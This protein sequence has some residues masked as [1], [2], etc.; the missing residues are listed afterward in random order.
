MAVLNTHKGLFA[1]NRLAFGIASAPALF[2]RRLESVL[3]GLPR[4]KVYLDDI[5][6][7]EKQNDN[8]TLRQVLER[9]RD[10]GLKLNR[11]KCR[12][13]EKQ[14]SFLGHKI[15]AT[16]LHPPENMEAITEAPRPETVSQLKSFLGLLTYYA[17]FLPNLATTLVPLYRL[18]AK[19]VRWQWKAE[20][21]KAFQAAKR[22]MVAA[23]LLVHYDPEKPL[24]LE[25]DA[26][27]V[28]VGAVLSHRIG[29]TDYPI[30]FRSRALTPAE[31]NYSQLEKE[32]LALVFGVTKFRDYLL[33]KHFTLVTDH[34][35]LTGLFHPERPIPHMAAAR[36]QRWALLL[37]AYHYDIEYRQGQLN[38]NADALSRLPL[39]CVGD[40]G[41]Q[42]PMEYVLYT[43]SLNSMTLSAQHL[44]EL[45]RS[46][47][48]LHQIRGW[49][50]HGWPRQLS[51]A[52][53]HLMPYF[54]RR[55]ELTAC[56]EMLYWG[57]RVVLPEAARRCMLKELH[58]SHP[59]I[60][61]MKRTA[62]ALF[63]YPGL[64]RDIEVL[65][66]SCPQ[67]I[68]C[69]PMPAAEVPSPWPASN[70]PWYRLH[71][72]FAGPISGFQVFVLVDAD[73]KWIEAIPL[74]TATAETTIQV[75]QGI[76][77]RFGLPYCLVSDNGPQFSSATLSSFLKESQVK[78]IRTAPYHPQSN[79]LAERA[80]RTVKEGLRKNPAGTLQERLI[81]FLFRYRTTPLEGGKSPA[82][83]LLGFRPRTRLTASLTDKKVTENDC[84]AGPVLGAATAP[85]RY[86]PGRQVWSRQFQSARKWMPATVVSTTGARMVTLETPEGPQ[87]RHVDQL[88]PRL[89]TGSS[90]SKPSEVQTGDEAQCSAEQAAAREGSDARVV[91]SQAEDQQPPRRSTRL[92]KPP[93]RLTY[94]SLGGRDVVLSS[95]R[96]VTLSS[97]RADV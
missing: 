67:C 14:V 45:S 5:I 15:D 6:I 44:A 28:G 50:T 37:S 56:H 9:L 23:E 74:K 8:S 34:K 42:E 97:P 35:P 63:W 69:W 26:S 32:A 33:A 83:L 13:R 30:S 87:R 51:V 19:G 48:T 66:K 47:D 12:F 52:Q 22:A 11:D 49:I 65:V 70:K 58:E 17:K 36:I 46:D 57:H 18:L 84:S 60:S 79:G 54:S 24:R 81:K 71:M 89:G 68:Q 93:D 76:F 53:Q 1:Y 86:Q 82:E 16:G 72:D 38:A 21:E 7:A 43:R 64:D 77:A 10:N 96:D 55:N 3:Q 39:P 91:G 61:A 41:G 62:R 88:R 94:S 78:H 75:L 59:G 31:R 20:H 92:R 40:R 85:T 2:Q 27:P 95:T 25:C 4:V 29:N 73:T 90:P 80:V